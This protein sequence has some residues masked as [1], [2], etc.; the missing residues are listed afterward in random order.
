MN[1]K[2]GLFDHPVLFWVAL[3]LIVAVALGTL[4]LVRQRR[5]I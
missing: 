3:A 4:L 1:F 2:V 5:W